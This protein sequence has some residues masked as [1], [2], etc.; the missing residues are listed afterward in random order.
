MVSPK[1]KYQLLAKCTKCNFRKIKLIEIEPANLL[2]AKLQ[3][4]TETAS[5]HGQHPDLNN[6]DITDKEI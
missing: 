5:A 3:F 2:P 1:K 4:A 6:F